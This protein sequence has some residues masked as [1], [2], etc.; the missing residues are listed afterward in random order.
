MVKLFI[1]ISSGMEAKEKALTGMMFAKNAK[2]REFAEDV[3]LIFFG[4]SEKALAQGDPD[5]VKSYRDLSE[6]GVI[7][8][9]C[10]KIAEDNKIGPSLQSMGLELEP[11]ASVITG[12]ASKGYEVITF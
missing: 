12:Y 7:S 5:F 2:L 3:R 10:I 6:A 4:P 8:T 1:I 9:A 11:V